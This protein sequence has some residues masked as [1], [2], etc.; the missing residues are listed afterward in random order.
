[1]GSYSII[2]KPYEDIENIKF[3][4]FAIEIKNDFKCIIFERDKFKRLMEEK[5]GINESKIDFKFN[6]GEKRV[7]D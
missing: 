1:M 6:F 7:F 3:Y 2:W 4:I 5:K